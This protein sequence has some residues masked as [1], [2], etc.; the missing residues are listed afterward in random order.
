MNNIEIISNKKGDYNDLSETY[1]NQE[2]LEK[3][4]PFYVKEDIS[5]LENNNHLIALYAQLIYLLENTKTSLKNKKILSLGSGSC[6]LES[7]LISRSNEKPHLFDAVDFS[8]HRIH[9][10]GPITLNYY[11]I[12]V[13]IKLYCGD[14]INTIP[15]T[16]SY[17]IIILCQSL[18][19]SESPILLL[20]EAS[21]LLAEN[22]IIIIMGEH[23]FSL[24]ER[25]F[26]LTKHFI[27]YFIDHRSYRLSH[28]LLPSYDDLFPPSIEKGDIHYSLS[29][30]HFMFKKSQLDIFLHDSNKK[31][32]IQGF[33]LKNKKKKTY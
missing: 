3:T 6:W 15:H 11:N 26:Q 33:V 8:K 32:G 22:G 2:D 30:Y 16:D 14:M 17:D 12:D 25:L 23:F 4:K 9:D 19:H 1:W 7:W 31:C 28:Y 18:H 20:K 27:K 24:R 5:K 21:Q 29:Q 13:P 10:L